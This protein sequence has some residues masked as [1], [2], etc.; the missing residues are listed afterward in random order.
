MHPSAP[1][2]LYPEVLKR[3]LVNQKAFKNTDFKNGRN[4]SYFGVD[5]SHNGVHFGDDE[6]VGSDKW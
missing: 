4:S 6:F 3:Q 1:S 5:K 2:K